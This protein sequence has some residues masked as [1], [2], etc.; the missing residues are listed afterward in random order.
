[1]GIKAM[2]IGSDEDYLQ[3][4]LR[5]LENKLSKKDRDFLEEAM[6][7]YGLE[8]LNEYIAKVKAKL[9]EAA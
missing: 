3:L 2:K 5:V 7:G 4:T 9:D 1:M 8:I 6:R